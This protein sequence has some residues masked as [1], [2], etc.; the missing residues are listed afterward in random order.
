MSKIYCKK[1]GSPAIKTRD[2]EG[3]AWIIC[4]ACGIKQPPKYYF[5]RNNKKIKF[6]V[7]KED[8]TDEANEKQI[9]LKQTR[10]QDFL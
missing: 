4:G 10:I 8:R 6:K 2:T 9:Q 1:C 7:E 3:Y 5:S